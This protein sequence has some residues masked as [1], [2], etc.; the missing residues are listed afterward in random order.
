MGYGLVGLVTL[1]SLG[2]DVLTVQVT[3]PYNFR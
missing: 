2:K 3:R 1:D